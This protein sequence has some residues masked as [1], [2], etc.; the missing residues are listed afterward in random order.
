MGWEILWPLVLGFYL[1]AVVEALVRKDTVARLLGDH[2]R[3]ARLRPP[4]ARASSQPRP[5][6][7][8]AWADGA[9]PPPLT[10]R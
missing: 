7:L 4:S 8:K 2:R 9:G 10:R 1:S 5:R 3:L 6:R